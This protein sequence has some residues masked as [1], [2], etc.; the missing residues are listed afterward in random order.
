MEAP[1]NIPS[2]K[3]V[4]IH[5]PTTWM[6]PK[7]TTR[8]PM[9]TMARE[10]FSLNRA[11]ARLPDTAAPTKPG[12]TVSDPNTPRSNADSSKCSSRWRLMKMMVVKMA[13]PMAAMPVR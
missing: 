12:K 7:V 4:G 9:N 11:S 10:G 6:A 13:K 3:T 8:A 5:I 1:R 2:N